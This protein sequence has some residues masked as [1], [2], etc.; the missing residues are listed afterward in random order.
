MPVQ[1][2]SMQDIVNMITKYKDSDPEMALAIYNGASGMGGGVADPGA[3][4]TALREA[5]GKEAASKFINDGTNKYGNPIM[6][7]STG[8][9]GSFYSNRKGQISEWNP[10]QFDPTAQYAGGGVVSQQGGGRPGASTALPTARKTVAEPGEGAGTV[11]GGSL[12]GGR[13]GTGNSMQPIGGNIRPVQSSTPRPSSGLPIGIPGVSGPTTHAPINTSYP[14]PGAGGGGGTKTQPPKEGN[15]NPTYPGAGSTAGYAEMLK[16]LMKS[17]ANANQAPGPSSGNIGYTPYGNPLRSF[18]P[19][20][21]IQKN[22]E[23]F[24]GKSGAGETYQPEQQPENY[25]SPTNQVWQ[26]L[27]KLYG[28]K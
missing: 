26:T 11:L 18:D 10:A 22:R 19:S 28:G 1:N 5:W 9:W 20:Y 2:Y 13:P 27:F 16:Q 12:G 15:P 3:V 23:Y 14:V 6:D 4:T 17:A 8:E 7:P 21:L 25:S 24:K